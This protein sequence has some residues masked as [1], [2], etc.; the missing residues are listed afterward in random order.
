MTA[1]TLDQIEAA[2]EVAMIEALGGVMAALE[3]C[4]VPVPDA[5]PETEKALAYIAK[6]RGVSQAQV[7]AD[8]LDNRV[9]GL[10]L[11]HL[12][13]VEKAKQLRESDPTP[14]PHHSTAQLRHPSGKFRQSIFRQAATRPKLLGSRWWG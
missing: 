14:T 1:T 8:S 3:N 7:L 5:D 13:A 2:S 6:A 11:D 10:L 4:G 9:R 12:D